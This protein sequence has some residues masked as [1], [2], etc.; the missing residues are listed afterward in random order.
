MPQDHLV[1]K[2][3]IKHALSDQVHLPRLQDAVMRT[4]TIVQLAY[5]LIKFLLILEFE[6]VD[7]NHESAEKLSNVLRDD[8]V[9]SNAI[10]AV[11]QAQTKAGRPFGSAR[12]AA[13]N[14]MKAGYDQLRASRQWP[15][16]SPSSANLSFVLRYSAEEMKTA[17]KNNVWMHFPK[18]VGAYIRKVLQDAAVARHGVERWRYVPAQAKKLVQRDVARY[19]QLALYGDGTIPQDAPAGFM[20]TLASMIPPIANPE[21]QRAYDLKTRWH[22]YVPYMIFINRILQELQVRMYSPLCLRTDFIPKHITLDTQGLIDIM[23]DTEYE[24]TLLKWGVEERLG[25]EFPF[26]DGKASFNVDIQGLVHPDRVSELDKHSPGHFRNAIWQEITKIASTSKHAPLRLGPLRFNNMI[27]TDGY[28]MSVHYVRDDKVGETKFNA[29]DE[30]KAERTQAKKDKKQKKKDEFESIS[31]VS[32]STK[33]FIL[34]K[35]TM[36]LS[37]DPGK[38]NLLCVTRVVRDHDNM[39]KKYKVV[40]YSSQQR[41][42]ESGQLRNKEER[43]RLLNKTCSDHVTTFQDLQMSLG[44]DDA[45]HK[46]CYSDNYRAYLKKRFGPDGR[47]LEDLYKATTF[48]R[49]AFRVFC[50]RKSADDKFINRIEKTF[51]TTDDTKLVILY[52]NWGRNPN[53]KHS[54]PTPGI[55]L[56][57][58]VHRRV[59][60]YTTYEG[61]TSSVCFDCQHYGLNE[62][63]KRVVDRE[64]EEQERNIHQLLRCQNVECSRWWSR[65]VL[66]ALNIGKQGLHILRHGCCAPCFSKPSKPSGQ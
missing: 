42:K 9:F 19:R 39:P 48:R 40:N 51:K 34:D 46:S 2:T 29:D 22:R 5:F 59:P 6:A 24:P 21:K 60:T 65:D 62:W 52:G 53:L 13:V 57:R 55:G 12:A 8:D 10:A 26:L 41:R 11:G 63:S 64:G 28:S 61:G 17:Y 50:G 35:N 47:E 3:R 31:D 49:Q 1:V 4:N 25:Q 7:F 32:K 66:G 20:Q 43:R 14:K 16:E 58:R 44:D 56:R 54:P 30:A 27:S 45:S 36:L 18:Y 37:A 33:D 38:G 15:Q 23:V